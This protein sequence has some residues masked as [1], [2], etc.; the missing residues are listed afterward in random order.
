[1]DTKRIIING[2]GILL[3]GGLMYAAVRKAGAL[4]GR[5]LSST[6][7]DGSAIF[8]GVSIGYLLSNVVM[9][10][11]LTTSEALPGTQV[12][13]LPGS[14]KPVETPTSGTAMG[15]VAARARAINA[16]PTPTVAAAEVGGGQVIDITKVK[17][18]N[19]D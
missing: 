17:G 8:G 7:V 10:K 12:T 5:T 9:D 6:I 13:S 2:I 18:N 19:G 15:N 16:V 1:M 14:D 3:G 11:L 4:R